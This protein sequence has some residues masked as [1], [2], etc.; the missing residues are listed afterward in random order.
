MRLNLQLYRYLQK[1]GLLLHFM[2]AKHFVNKIR[3][4]SERRKVC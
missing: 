1:Y 4:I 3:V 2:T